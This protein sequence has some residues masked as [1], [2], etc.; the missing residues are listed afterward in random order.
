MSEVLH[1]SSDALERHSARDVEG[2][3]VEVWRV[4]GTRQYV[5][6]VDGVELR[7]RHDWTVDAVNAG[8]AHVAVLR[9]AARLVQE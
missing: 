5:A 9:C 1:G 8:R 3:M 7:T 4:I 2:H 6:T